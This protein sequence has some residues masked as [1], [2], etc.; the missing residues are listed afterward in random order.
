[1]SLTGRGVA[2]IVVS[3]AEREAAVYRAGSVAVHRVTRVAGGR[4]KKKPET[5]VA[6]SRVVVYGCSTTETTGN[7]V[8]AVASRSIVAHRADVKKNS[9][10]PIAVCRTVAYAATNDR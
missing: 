1:R 5:V 4:A 7:A 10:A 6:V 3:P 9:V 2:D 8:A